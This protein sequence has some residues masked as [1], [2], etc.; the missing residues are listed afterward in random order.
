MSF[1]LIE[2][3]EKR[4]KRLKSCKKLAEVIQ[5]AVFNDGEKI[6]KA[7]DQMAYAA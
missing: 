5:R 6:E 1:K 2:S 3:T 4:W 7:E